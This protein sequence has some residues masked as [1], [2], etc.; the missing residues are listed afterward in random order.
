MRRSYYSSHS[1]F[2]D[3]IAEAAICDVV[4]AIGG[5][6]LGASLPETFTLHPTTKEP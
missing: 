3:Q 2:Q 4:I 5:C 1:G 6:C